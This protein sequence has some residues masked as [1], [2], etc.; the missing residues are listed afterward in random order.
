MIKV[1]LLFLSL[2]ISAC[3][4]VQRLFCLILVALDGL[5]NAVVIEEGGGS[6]SL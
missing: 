3:S 6:M 4:L 5:G 2:G 1:A